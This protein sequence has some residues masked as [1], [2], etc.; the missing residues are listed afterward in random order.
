MISNKNT[1]AISN[2]S[3]SFSLDAAAAD[4]SERLL[5]PAPLRRAGAVGRL[6]RARRRAARAAAARARAAAAALPESGPRAAWSSRTRQHAPDIVSSV[7][8]C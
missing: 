4:P 6:G 2:I 1:S 5:Q 7:V 3:S 8:W